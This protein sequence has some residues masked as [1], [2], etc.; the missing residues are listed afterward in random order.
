VTFLIFSGRNDFTIGVLRI[1]SL[2]P[3]D[4]VPDAVFDDSGNYGFSFIKYDLYSVAALPLD[5]SAYCHPS[6]K[7]RRSMTRYA[8]WHTEQKCLSDYRTNLKWL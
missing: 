2:A 7:N 5:P 6:R 3:T 1:S 4:L 8:F